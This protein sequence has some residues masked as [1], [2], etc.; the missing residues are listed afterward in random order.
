MRPK[1]YQEELREKQ[2]VA[3]WVGDIGTEGHLN[4]YLGTPFES[5]WDEEHGF[6][7]LIHRGKEI[8]VGDFDLG[9]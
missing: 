2:V 8:E 5:D 3:V 4:E 9:I 1:L 7:I 6:A